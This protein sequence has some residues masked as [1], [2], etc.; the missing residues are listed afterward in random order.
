VRDFTLERYGRLLDHLR[1]CVGEPCGVLAWHGQ[2]PGRGV[3]LRH[4][5]DRKPGNAL[6]MAMLE[7]K[8]GVRSTYYFRVVGTAFAPDVIREVSRL[9][10]EVGYHYEDLTLAG[11]DVARAQVLFAEHLD[12]M[13]A[14]APVKTIAMHGSPFSPHNNLDMWRHGSLAEHEIVAEAFLTIDY[15]GLPYFTDTGRSWSAGGANLRDM[16]P[17]AVAPP[18]W[19]QGTGDLMRFV[20]D[21]RPAAI[22]LS[23][24]PE[25]WASTPGDWLL[26]LGKDRCVNGAK[27]LLRA[28]R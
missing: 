2:R 11:G 21:V 16:P 22:A 10:H 18:D 15:L 20:D 12:R 23:A 17:S 25:R 19:V 5:V 13:R 26:Q 28:I 24:H 7:A 3:L 4:D 14:L 9:G 1:A 6:A 27:R 8:R